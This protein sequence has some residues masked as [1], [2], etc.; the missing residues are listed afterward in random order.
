MNYFISSHSVPGSHRKRTRAPACWPQQTEVRAWHL[1][2]GERR[3][4][5]QASVHWGPSGIQGPAVITNWQSDGNAGSC[6]LGSTHYM[7]GSLLALGLLGRFRPLLG[8]WKTPKV[9]KFTSHPQ[10]STAGERNTGFL[11]N[12]EHSFLQPLLWD[13]PQPGKET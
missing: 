8:P 6:C 5:C 7:P 10:T 3:P 9:V 12:G 1:D 2:G 11:E 4:T 13:P